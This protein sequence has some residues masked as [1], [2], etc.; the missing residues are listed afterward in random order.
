MKEGDTHSFREYSGTEIKLDGEDL[1]IMKE[2]EALGIVTGTAKKESVLA[3]AIDRRRCES[4]SGGL[5]VAI[6]QSSIAP[7]PQERTLASKARTARSL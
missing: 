4:K 2:E 3:L 7:S 1:L 6:V 5:V